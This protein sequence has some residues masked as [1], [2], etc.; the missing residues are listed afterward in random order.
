MTRIR[1]ST[2]N[3]LWRSPRFQK[4]SST[5]S[6][7]EWHSENALQHHGTQHRYLHLVPT[8]FGAS[9]TDHGMPAAFTATMRG[10]S[11]KRQKGGGR[12]VNISQEKLPLMNEQLVKTLMDRSFNSSADFVKLRLV[13]EKDSKTPPETKETT[14]S[15]AIRT[16]VDF[17]LDLVEIDLRSHDLPVVRA[18][19]FEAKQYRVN[20]TKA[21]NLKS[22]K[23]LELKEFRFR[24]KS[25]DYDFQRKLS[26]VREALQKG[27]RCK[28]MATCPEKFIADGSQP[29]GAGSVMER[30]VEE[31][32]ETG[33]LVK[34][35]D[36]NEEKTNSTV[37][38][39]PRSKAKKKS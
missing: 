7:V 29:K 37:T 17:G 28:V 12:K 21:K 15:D 36:I 35:P 30:I 26:S 2:V 33:E 10:L 34:A 19:H 13:V 24:A 3:L 18:V 39:M 32:A 27:H 5:A 8:C 11:I 31:L 38:F 25:A 14:L 6:A 4:W 20:K 9:I 16:S 23:D 22:N 1:P